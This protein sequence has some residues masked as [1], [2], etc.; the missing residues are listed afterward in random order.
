MLNE[1]FGRCL[2]AR[3][4]IIPLR[5]YSHYNSDGNV[6]EEGFIG[7]MYTALPFDCDVVG[8]DFYLCIEE[9][10]A[11]EYSKFLTPEEALEDYEARVKNYA[12]STN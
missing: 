2:E 3:C 10:K 4:F 1:L 5:V 8:P 11:G 9:S 6:S 12:N 7:I